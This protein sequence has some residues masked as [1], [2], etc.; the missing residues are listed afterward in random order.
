MSYIVRHKHL[1]FYFVSLSNLQQ[2]RTKHKY[3]YMKN[4]LIFIVFLH[5]A[6]YCSIFIL[7]SKI[8]DKKL[9][10][11]NDAYFYIYLHTFFIEN[12]GKWIETK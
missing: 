8:S 2:F 5:S 7:D 6:N 10:F 3:L 4:A 11:Y 9:C 1:K 12:S